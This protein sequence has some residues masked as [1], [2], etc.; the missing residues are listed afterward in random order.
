MEQKTKAAILHDIIRKFASGGKDI[1]PHDWK[2]FVEAQNDGYQTGPEIGTKV[3]DFTLPDQHGRRRALAELM[4]RANGLLLVSQPQRRLVTLLPATSSS[5]WQL[6][7]GKLKA[8][9]VNA[10]SITYDSR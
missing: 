9:G 3:P 1:T 8:H 10:A 4:Q 5:S 7:L 6:S 2:A